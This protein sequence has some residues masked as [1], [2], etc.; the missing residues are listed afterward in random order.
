MITSFLWMTG[1]TIQ[2]ARRQFEEHALYA[3]FSR[4]T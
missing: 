3:K 1:K 4:E 2:I